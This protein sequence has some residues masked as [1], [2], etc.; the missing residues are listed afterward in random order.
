[1]SIIVYTC[2]TGGYDN[3]LPP[4]VASQPGVRFIC[5]TDVPQMPDVLPWEYRPVHRVLSGASLYSTRRTSCLPKILPHLIL[6]ECEFSVW[7]DGNFR[8]ASPA[9]DLVACLGDA[10]L[11][12]YR[13]PSRGCL[14]KEADALLEGGFGTAE[15]VREE[16][17]FYRTIGHP[18]GSGLW[19]SGMVVRRHAAV[20]SAF[21]EHWWK[22][23]AAGCELDQMSL[24][25][26]VHNNPCVRVADLS[27]DVYNSPHML[28]DGWHAAWCS[29]EAKSEARPGRLAVAERVDRLCALAGDGG[30]S[31]SAN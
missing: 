25:V 9:S 5:F 31:W 28:F 18:E 6:P 22:L 17:A 30:Y 12:L 14:Y 3:L 24:A 7:H 10:D 21:N 19:A 11:A 26:A 2:V 27:G 13:H 20:T 1:M 23:Y 4:L 29:E 8:L 16:A 15:L